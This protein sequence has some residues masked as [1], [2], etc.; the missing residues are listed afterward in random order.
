V[1]SCGSDSSVES[2]RALH[3]VGDFEA[4]VQS[5]RE[6]LE[7]QPDDPELNFLYGVSLMKTGEPGL[8][9][10]SFRKAME[11]PDW[12]VRA[13][14]QIAAA[15]L[16]RDDTETAEAAASQALE[17]EPD[18]VDA[19][20]LRGLS[21]VSSRRNWDGAL[22]DADRALELDPDKGDAEVIR[23]VALLGLDRIDEAATA[24]ERVEQASQEG[25]PG[26][27][28]SS[29]FCAARA[30]FSKEKGDADEARQ[31][32]AECLERFPTAFNVVQEAVK[33]HGE[34]GELA[35]AIEIL[36]TAYEAVPEAAG[37]RTAL[38]DHLRA[39]G[40]VAGAQAILEEAT[41]HE[42]P[43]VRRAAWVELASHYRAVEDY[44]AA[45]RALEQALELSEGADPDLEFALADVLIQAGEPD[46][47]LALAETM[48]AAA[49][50]DL[51][52]GRV[53]LER[54]APEEAL[55][56]FTS[57]L[58]LWPDN[59]V[60]RYYAALAAERLGDFE[61]AIE[62]YR[63]SMRADPELTDARLRLARMHVAERQLRLAL[64]ALQRSGGTAP[65]DVEADL[66]HVE[67][68][69]RSGMIAGLPNP[70]PASL[71]DPVHWG[72][73]AGAVGRGLRDRF[74]EKIALDF[75]LQVE[76]LD[77][78][79]PHN[80]AVLRLLLDLHASQDRDVA[81]AETMIRVALE[82]HPDSAAL[83]AVRARHLERRGAP[84][85]EIDA[86][87][88]RALELD[89][90]NAHALQDAAR[91]AEQQGSAAAALDLWLRAAEADPEASEAVRTA[92]QGLV[93]AGRDEEAVARLDALLEVLPHDADAAMQRASLLLA[94]SPQDAR[95]LE[96]A[97]R[98]V[99]FGGRDDAVEFLASVH[100]GRGE[101]ALADQVIREAE[102]AKAARERARQEAAAKAAA[103]AES[104]TAAGTGDAT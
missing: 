20:V 33:F 90:A 83:H 56:H 75:L 34:R 28:N 35:R 18:N 71:E 86:A 76:H 37:Y 38:A 31:R 41:T 5:G 95:A 16:T 27:E 26:L 47:A 64:S 84:A 99:R 54:G 55:E 74:G 30:V 11:H 39:S 36:R 61:R 104:E 2:L 69:A 73:V 17:A 101:P 53:A 102:E 100:R 49:Y 22:A 60:A 44:P 81:E 92:A 91:R 21:R 43:D 65:H 93:E 72:R 51:V 23:L 66:L 77:W 50:R 25:A 14:I 19:L 1:C 67:L 42:H 45:A 32:F 68:Q 98:S 85:A 6:L 97:Q 57:G 4:A 63:Y 48:S 103:G 70:L 15:A 79:A 12:R 89:P 82:R 13:A 46:R 3:A 9:L 80:A 24:I 78:T 40:D 87:Y 7:Q 8:A 29:G 59:A 58:R 10:W 62:E 96:L 88:A 52:R 94:K